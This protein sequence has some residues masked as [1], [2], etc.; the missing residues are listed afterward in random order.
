MQLGSKWL[1]QD[2]TVECFLY[3]LIYAEEYHVQLYT[4]EKMW[5]PAKRH[6]SKGLQTKGR[7]DRG[8]LTCISHHVHVSPCNICQEN[9]YSRF[10][11][12]KEPEWNSYMFMFQSC[13]ELML[14]TIRPS[15]NTCD[16]IQFMHVTRYNL[17]Y[18]YISLNLSKNCWSFSTRMF[19]PTFPILWMLSI[20]QY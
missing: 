6:I 19:D 13:S 7:F 10:F 15:R 4:K 8:S 16:H 5:F 17:W 14:I 9:I 3:F 18:I 20:F 11:F 1:C 12:C 2:R